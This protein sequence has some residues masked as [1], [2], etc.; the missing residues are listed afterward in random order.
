[1]E[2]EM[3]LA[4]MG[5]MPKIAPAKATPAAKRNVTPR[6]PVSTKPGNAEFRLFHAWRA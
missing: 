1:M 3:K 2:M 6:R 4:T 5:L